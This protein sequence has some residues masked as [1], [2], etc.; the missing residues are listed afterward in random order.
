[1]DR[2]VYLLI[3]AGGRGVRMG[4]EVP[5]QFRPWGGR[6]LLKATVEAFLAP[7]MPRLAG[8][9]L[10][11]PPDR[12]EEV[13]TWAFGLPT[14]VVAGGATR[15]ASVA[16]ALAALPDQPDAAV[17]IHD[18]VRP[19]PPEAPIREALAALDAVA[20]AVLAEPSTDTL[21]RVDAEG[22]IV[23]TEP[24]EL[25]FRAQTPQVSTLGLWRKAFAQAAAAGLEATDDVA[26]LE[27]LGLEV[28]VIPS[29]ATNVKLTTPEDWARWEPHPVAEPATGPTP[30]NQI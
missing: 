8:L 29:P 15:Q 9:S 4:G 17:L 20:G 19:F 22:L 30:T 23:A 27:A 24:R 6:P 10:A 16:S 25:I 14:W 12:L 21:K 13:R 11:V 7:G 3:P 28:K 26:L 1:M 5:K 18:G 2:P